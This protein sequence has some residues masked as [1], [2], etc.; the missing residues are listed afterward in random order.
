MLGRLTRA[1]A[2]AVGESIGG[3]ESLFHGRTRRRNGL[4]GHNQCS[5]SPND[6]VITSPVGVVTRKAE[7][8]QQVRGRRIATNCHK[9]E[10]EKAS[11]LA[12]LMQLP[13]YTSGRH[14]GRP[15]GV[16]KL[17]IKNKC[18]PGYISRSGL[19]SQALNLKPT[20][21]PFARR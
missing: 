6:V 15:I 9:T 2:A 13:R 5:S 7:Q 19:L 11:L 20:E 3:H 21:T 4:G 1:T 8:P 10:A 16:G 12:Q 17:E 18:A 14:K